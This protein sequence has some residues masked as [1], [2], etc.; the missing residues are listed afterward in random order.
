MRKNI[1][2]EFKIKVP[3][4][5]PI[6]LSASERSTKNIIITVSMELK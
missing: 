3:E 2:N 6:V 4:K 5:N 1:Y